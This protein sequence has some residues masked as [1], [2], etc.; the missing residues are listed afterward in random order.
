MKK[1]TKAPEFTHVVYCGPKIIGVVDQYQIFIGGLPPDLEEYTNKYPLLK[2]LIV[3]LEQLKEVRLG[4]LS[5]KG[6]WAS[7]FKKIKE[8]I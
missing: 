7:I 8:G 2:Q 4:L 3:P 5:G 6:K 1:K